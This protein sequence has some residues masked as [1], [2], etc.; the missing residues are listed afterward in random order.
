[1]PQHLAQNVKGDEMAKDLSALNTS[2]IRSNFGSFVRYAFKATHGEALGNQPYIDHMCHVISQMID[3]KTRRLL[4]NLP[5]QHLKSF[6][7]TICL[8]AFLLGNNPRLRIIVA[9]FIDAFAESLCSKIRDM[10]Q[11]PWY[12]KAFTTRIK[13]GHARANDFATHENGGV[14][15]VAATG[16]ITGRTAD[17]IIYDDPHE[18]SDWNNERKLMLVKDNFNTILSRLHD[19]AMGPVIVIAHRVSEN[20]L[21]AE[22]LKD[23][24]WERLRLPLIAGRRLTYELGHDEWV[25]EKGELL[26]P[27]AYPPKEVERLQRT[28]VAPPFELF[29]QQGLGS[30]D[31]SRPRAEHFQSFEPRLLPVGPL[32]LSIDPGHGGGPNASRTAI[33]AWIQSGKNYY[34]IDEY[35][36]LCDAEG[37]RHNFWSFSRKYRPS[38]ALI[39]Q[40]ADGPALYARIRQRVQFEI[41]LI[42][43]RLSKVI[44]FNNHM[45]KIRGQRIFLPQD[46]GWRDQFIAEILAFPGAFSDRGDAMSQYLDYT[47]TNPVIKPR[48]PRETGIGIALGSTSPQ[49]P[50]ETGIGIA[51]GS[52]LRRRG[53]Y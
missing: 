28:Q 3:G 25:R 20:D 44:R 38:V 36:D 1:M 50:R 37:L 47:D 14:F 51:F 12:Q 30:Q 17:W 40:T 31:V 48:P 23:K 35:C 29:Y 32:V 45:S 7:V 9:A 8:T 4:V 6:V 49:L 24:D 33:Q 41:K 18:I 52:I 26:R 53:Q 27:K 13:E 43:P 46:A 16:A 22:L 11:T 34:L 39:E 42:T 10:M 2:L 15:A 21:S 19:K 5:P